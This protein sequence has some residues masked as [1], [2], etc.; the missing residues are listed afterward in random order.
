MRF[1]QHY[2]QCSPSNDQG[3][4]PLNVE[5]VSQLLNLYTEEVSQILNL[6]TEEVSQ[7]LNLYTEEVSQPLNFI[8]RRCLRY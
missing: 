2:C 6:Y 3:I 1:K 7:I 5:S 4:Y 8:Q